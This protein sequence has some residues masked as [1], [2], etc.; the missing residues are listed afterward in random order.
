MP[1]FPPKRLLLAAFLLLWLGACVEDPDESFFP[2]PAA[3]YHGTWQVMEETGFS[4]PQSYTMTITEDTSAQGDILLKGLYNVSGTAVSAT[5]N[6]TDINLP[7]QRSE[8][9]Q[10][11]GYGTANEDFTLLD[12]QFTANDGAGP[13]EVRAQA[14]R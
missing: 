12:L 3:Q 1:Y 4:A 10:F 9:I 14:S 7:N 5:V 2:D 13:D 11:F 6:G 8:G